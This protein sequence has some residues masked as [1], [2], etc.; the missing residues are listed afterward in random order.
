[1]IWVFREFFWIEHLD[2]FS[3][4]TDMEFAATGDL[5]RIHGVDEHLLYESRIYLIVRDNDFLASRE[6]VRRRT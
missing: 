6:T 3:G 4:R 1:M 5:G 2:E